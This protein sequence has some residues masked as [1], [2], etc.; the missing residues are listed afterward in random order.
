MTWDL[1][2]MNH[3]FR[4]LFANGKSNL[5]FFHRFLTSLKV[6]VKVLCYRIRESG[7]CI[8]ANKNDAP[9]CSIPPLSNCLSAV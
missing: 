9:V 6:L 2:V 1:E 3:E 8:A 5:F 7:I 4:N